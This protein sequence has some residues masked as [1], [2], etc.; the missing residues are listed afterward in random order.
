M[1]GKTVRIWK[2]RKTRAVKA[3]TSEERKL[4]RKFWW[5]IGN[6]DLIYHYLYFLAILKLIPDYFFYIYVLNA[7]LLQRKDDIEHAT[8]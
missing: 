1:S 2:K 7:V 5:K 8:D 4:L 6:F 3:Q